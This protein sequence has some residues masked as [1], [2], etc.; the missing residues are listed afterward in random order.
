[1]GKIDERATGDEEAA[2]SG[3]RE[4]R[5]R[6]QRRPNVPLTA[7]ATILVIGA[8]AFAIYRIGELVR[9]SRLSAEFAPVERVDLQ[10]LPASPGEVPDAKTAAEPVLRVAIAPV[11]SPEK[12]LKTYQGLVNYL[13]EKLDR[14][15]VFLQGGA[16]EQVNDLVRNRQCEIAL[17]CTYAF[18]RGEEDFAMEA[19]AVPVIGGNDHYHSHIIVPRSSGA[20][21]L[22]DLRGKRFGA[23]NR[24]SNSG[25]LYPMVW[26]E[27]H[28][29]DSQTFFGGNLVITG[30]HDRS[31][32][33]VALQRVD[34][35]AVDSLVYEQM[36]D[37]DPSLAEK[38]KIIHTSPEFGMPPVVA[39][40]D[41]A[42]DLKGDI[43]SLLLRMHDDRKGREVLSPLRFDRFI[44]PRDGLFDSV[45]ENS[46]YL[47]SRQ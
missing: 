38:T 9:Q 29:E 46:K 40:H 39:P 5:N 42:E 4:Q 23:V 36:L 20:A 7:A 1:M 45:R 28:G 32:R 22:L 10:R 27:E 21:S 3:G 34:G 11:V 43:L 37:E 16:Y 41:L 6:R 14:E 44:R 31:V 47:E 8:V 25:Y 15:P 30:S 33:Q 26:L 13:A 35:A 17:V 24:L 19:L 2:A 12:S 18:I